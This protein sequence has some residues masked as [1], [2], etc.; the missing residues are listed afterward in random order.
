MGIARSFHSR[1]PSLHPFSRATHPIPMT[2]T[3]TLP[4]ILILG[5]ALAG[6][7][8]SL[9]AAPQKKKGKVPFIVFATVF[10]EQGL[11][12]P[13]AEARVR[14]A[15]EKKFRWEE[16]SDRR[17][18]FAMRVP[19]GEEYE[20]SV[21]AKGYEPITEKVDARQSSRVDLTLHLVPASKQKRAKDKKSEVKPNEPKP[22]EVKPL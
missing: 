11:A 12:F 22:K 8:P 20:L 7:A 1:P 10:T 13:G 3:R 2:R 16:I 15:G 5:L 6:A 19:M 4:A 21:T 9:A 17:G 18:E 14:R